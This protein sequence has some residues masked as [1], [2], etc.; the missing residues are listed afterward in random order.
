[1]P[2]VGMSETR[3]LNSAGASLS[4]S[5]SISGNITTATMKQGGNKLMSKL[6]GSKISSVALKE[7][8][9]DEQK[10]SDECQQSE[11]RIQSED[12]Q[13]TSEHTADDDPA[14]LITPCPFIRP[15]EHKLLARIEP[16]PKLY[17]GARSIDTFSTTSSSLAIAMNREEAHRRLNNRLEAENM[18]E[19]FA[20]LST[21]D[22]VAV[23]SALDSVSAP[24]TVRHQERIETEDD[25]SLQIARQLE[26]VAVTAAQ[27]SEAV[28]HWRYY[29]E[30]Y[31]K[32]RGFFF[33]LRVPISNSKLT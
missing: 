28:H 11:E 17:S 4:K 16:M 33:G 19:S 18:E 9:I 10:Q 32:V 1:M 20:D 30:C 8:F 6:F 22:S 15:L 26:Y 2:P 7:T 27:G 21:A 12:Y 31:S 13:Q 23:E 24:P 3:E 29:I 14:G 25:M 5:A